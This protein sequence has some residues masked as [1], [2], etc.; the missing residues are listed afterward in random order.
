MEFPDQIALITYRI[1]FDMIFRFASNFSREIPLQKPAKDLLQ[2][3]SSDDDSLNLSGAATAA[4]GV[5][6]GG[7][8]GTRL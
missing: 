7:K 3:L 1:F 2:K 6:Y 8:V 5:T 4:D